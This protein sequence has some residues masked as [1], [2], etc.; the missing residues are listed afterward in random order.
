MIKKC[1]SLIFLICLVVLMD[2][3]FSQEPY[4]MGTT[5]ANFLEIGVGGAGV[6]MGDAYVASGGDMSSIYWNPAGLAT[7]SQN[8]ALFM[9][10]PWVVDVNTLFTGFGLVLPSLG[11]LAF[12]VFGISYGNID[13]TTL[14]YQNGTGEEYTAYDYSFSAT[15]ARSIAN[16][17]SFGITGKYISSKIWHTN[18]SAMAMDLGVLVQTG[19]FSPT[20]KQD[21]GLKIGM[22]IA[23]Y[24]GRMRY[25][26]F[27]L[28]F[29]VD[30]D[31]TAGGNYQNVQGKYRM[32]DWEL[33]LIFRVGISVDPIVLASHRLTLEV[34]ALHPNNMSESINLGAQ[35]K[36]G[37]PG[38][39]DFYL[40][41]G[42]KGLFMVDSQYGP[43]FGGGI[44]WYM[45]P[46][47]YINIDYAFRSIG[48]LGNVH[49]TSLSVAF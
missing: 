46:A 1:S 18:A 40:R 26:G 48:D 8:Q 4:R 42:Y 41:G 29:P 44:K 25:D 14:E 49:C 47:R 7:M 43:T 24:G 33:P 23:N 32:Q 37:A 27:D 36:F 35:Y 16:W 2:S 45:G 20:S 9:Y 39:G 3:G 17:F 15:Y 22:S 13:V 34:D 30:I 31:P 19:F 11:T 10:Q 28:L 6:A 38:F 12:G 21:D 5:T